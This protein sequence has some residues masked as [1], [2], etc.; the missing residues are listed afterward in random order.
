MDFGDI[1]TMAIILGSFLLPL[2]GKARRA[3]KNVIPEMG[4]NAGT[5][6][7]KE[8]VSQ[9]SFES[10]PDD[11]F[12]AQEEQHDYFT[13]ETIDPQPQYGQSPMAG[14]QVNV[15][16]MHVQTDDTE[17][18][19]ESRPIDGAFSDLERSGIFNLRQAILYQTILETKY[20]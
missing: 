4:T 8:Y 16:S 14:A 19:R 9:D 3:M 7:Q 15:A 6:F 11:M 5:S 12:E 20:V 10:E 17:P 1:L 13:Y 18:A 2:V